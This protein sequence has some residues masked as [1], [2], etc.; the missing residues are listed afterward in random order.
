MEQFSILEDQR[1]TREMVRMNYHY[2]VTEL[3]R[4]RDTEP[5]RF[6]AEL[7]KP[8]PGMA[9]DMELALDIIRT[10]QDEGERM[11]LIESVHLDEQTDQLW[12]Q[13]PAW[14]MKILEEFR[15][16]FDS[17]EAQYRYLKTFHELIAKHIPE[18]EPT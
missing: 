7:D 6:L 2:A 18:R 11:S 17:D 16:L 15:S 9:S 5:D 13:L 1:S 3:M 12:V 8:W 10:C 14:Q 4:L